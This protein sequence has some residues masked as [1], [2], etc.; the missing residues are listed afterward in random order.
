MFD[1][2]NNSGLPQIL[3]LS[4]NRRVTITKAQPPETYNLKSLDL[5]GNGFQLISNFVYLFKKSTDYLCLLFVLVYDVSNDEIFTNVKI[6]H[7]EIGK[8]FDNNEFPV[9][10]LGNKVDLLGST[11]QRRD[12]QQSLR[13][14]YFKQDIA[15]FARKIMK[16]KYLECSAK[17]N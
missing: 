8:C 1:L 10:I 9:I 4:F 11:E 14:F 6:L 5:R 12:R 3:N 16:V 15:N 17:Y 13:L 7:N 2:I